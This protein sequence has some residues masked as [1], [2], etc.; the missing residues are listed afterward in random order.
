MTGKAKAE[1]VTYYNEHGE[2][3]TEEDGPLKAAM[4]KLGS[5]AARLAL[6]I[7][8]AND[9]QSV[10]VDVEAMKS[11]ITI[12]NW[13]EEQARR[14]YQGF[15]ESEQEQERRVAREWIAKQGGSTTRRDFARNG[16]GRLRSRAGEVLGDLLTAGL[17]K[18]SPQ[19][20]R[21]A[22]KYVLCDC[23]S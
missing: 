16:P 19:P 22:D 20:G 12:S 13:F 1:F 6:I 23:D 11:G 15:E 8:L 18:L 10:E 17:A 14:V 21:H 9:P 4:S 3:E 2:R 5:A 7:Q